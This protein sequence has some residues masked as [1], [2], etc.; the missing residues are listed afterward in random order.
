MAGSCLGCKTGRP[1]PR[2][3]SGRRP[4]HA[5]RAHHPRPTSCDARERARQAP[6]PVR[7]VTP[8][9]AAELTAAGWPYLDV[10]TPPEFAE[11]RA[12]GAVN[13]PSLV[14]TPSGAGG[15][16]DCCLA[17]GAQ[18]LDTRVVAGRASRPP[19]QPRRAAPQAWA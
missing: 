14:E 9:A 4:S 1:V 12:K 19:L 17:A 8:Q 10:R 5:P 16:G 6:L 3:H 7:G 15:A 2:A 18:G 11:L 13:V